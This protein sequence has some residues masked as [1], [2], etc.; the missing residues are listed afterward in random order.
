MDPLQLM[1]Y[2]EEDFAKPAV[3]RP[4]TGLT[5]E[6]DV[7]GKADPYREYME[8]FETAEKEHVTSIVK[9]PRYM[10]TKCTRCDKYTPSAGELPD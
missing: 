2:G 8:E 6:R 7:F 9:I 5:M 3:P 4:M 1:N 10:G